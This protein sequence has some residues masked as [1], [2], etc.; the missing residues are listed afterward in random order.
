MAATPK[1]AAGEAPSKDNDKDE[2]VVILRPK[3]PSSIPERRLVLTPGRPAVSIGR[4]SKDHSKGFIPAGDNAWLENPVMSRDHAELFAQFDDNPRAVYLKDVN[5]FHGTYLTTSDGR[6]KGQKLVPNEPVKLTHGDTI[7]FG[8][9]IYRSSK[10]Y[11]PCF[12][13]YLVEA[14]T[15]KPDDLPHRSFT[16]PDDVD[17]E[18][19]ED[20][21]NEDD[22]TI[23]AVH[24]RSDP[25][26]LTSAWSPSVAP[27]HLTGAKR[28]T[29]ST[30]NGKTSSNVIDLTSE[31]ATCQSDVEPRTIN[32]GTP[33]PFESVVDDSPVPS[34]SSF[35]DRHPTPPARMRLSHS[36][37]G[38]IL[39]MPSPLLVPSDD[40][41]IYF[42]DDLSDEG[43]SSD[44]D[45][46]PESD[47]D[48]ASEFSEEMS[49]LSGA[50]EPLRTHDD[51]L[52]EIAEIGDEEEL[53]DDYAE[54]FDD[55]DSPCTDAY[56][57]ESVELYSSDEEE[58]EQ[59]ATTESSNAKPHTETPV[60]NAH[61]TMHYE[62]GS[63]HFSSPLPV[64]LAPKQL[65]IYKPPR[66]R[67]PSPSDAA[68]FQ[69]RP[70]LDLLPS[71]SRAQ[72]L[73]EKS[74][75]FEFFAAREKNRA[76]VNQND[77]TAPIKT[78][79][80][81]PVDD[82]FP[83]SGI[84]SDGDNDPVATAVSNASRSVSPSLSCAPGTVVTAETED[85]SE[86][87]DTSSIK[88]GDNNTHQYSAW[89][90]SGDQFI[91]NPPS[92]PSPACQTVLGRPPAELDMTSA[93]TFQQSKLA[94][95]AETVSKTRRLP[96]EDLLAQEPKPC[97]IASQ[98]G[99]EAPALGD[100]PIDCASTPIKRSYEEAFNQSEDDAAS[101]CADRVIA[102]CSPRIVEAK[103]QDQTFSKNVI[104]RATMEKYVDALMARKVEVHDTPKHEPTTTLVQPE[105]PRAVKRMRLATAAAQVVACVALGSAATFSYL[106]NTAP[107]L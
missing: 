96:I 82:I 87:P 16:V 58:D 61:E 66:D 25:I 99:P 37:D 47:L 101:K 46:Y 90:A 4:S 78:I 62:A 12:V 102:P 93:Y 18:E 104:D 77:S 95:A 32:Q 69:R 63:M 80:E 44:P 71:D 8:I 48:A 53:S 55:S 73:G 97:S 57:E 28:S 94:T 3:N 54:D 31:V 49:E 86:A 92:E 35:L 22:L 51:T 59:D 75:K 1:S 60:M 41:D 42:H 79:L 40:E 19:D 39:F 50:D 106:V 7:Q 45:Q 29:S 30:V 98:P 91:N 105:P 100:S 64:S 26:D 5:S 70:L 81:T 36:S 52:S 88:L 17:D 103:D 74:G 56:D 85:S 33:Y 2:I 38:R 89:S 76:A 67:D 6:N 13:D 83:S 34:V 23:T 21:E 14:T 10:T 43:L 9:D 65:N 84:Q 27:D 24:T 107:V 72:Q 68:L 15:Q 11:P 20:C